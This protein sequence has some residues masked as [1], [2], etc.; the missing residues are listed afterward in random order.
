ML[1]KIIATDFDMT[2]ADTSGCL[3]ETLKRT[4]P[5]ESFTKLEKN[6]SELNGL[7]L[8]K[9]LTKFFDVKDMNWA[10]N[11]FHENYQAYG[12]FH[13]KLMPGAL[14]AME[15]IR[16]SG[17]KIAV[18]SAKSSVNLQKTIDYLQ[19]SF[20]YIMGDLDGNGKTMQLKRLNAELYL[21]D[22]ESDVQAAQRA[23][24][25]C[26]RISKVLSKNV[27]EQGWNLTGLD[28]F[29]NWFEKYLSKLV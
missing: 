24:V 27:L 6:L 16:D 28:E 9:I 22:M 11:K 12:L 17:Y 3:L 19:L 7:K 29:P 5:Q 26:L 21:G 14:R 18:V 23:G 2:I 15:L 20:D 10:R 13:A 25:P 1:E 8:E 4:I